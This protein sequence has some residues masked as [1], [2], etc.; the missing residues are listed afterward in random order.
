MAKTSRSSSFALFLVACVNFAFAGVAIVCYA[1]LALAMAM[2]PGW[3]PWS[4]AIIVLGL[5]ICAM[6]IVNG[7]GILRR[8]KITGRILTNVLMALWI[9]SVVGAKVV[10]GF[11][12]TGSYQLLGFLFYPVLLLVVFNGP[13]KKLF[14]RR[15]EVA[16]HPPAN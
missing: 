8:R 14:E 4:F 2:Q 13:Y 1:I 6:Q 12:G 7:I 16:E 5:L 9:G 10:E 15:D 3:P 11:S